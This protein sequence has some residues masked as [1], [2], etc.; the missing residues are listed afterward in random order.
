MKDQLGE[1]ADGLEFAKF[2]AKLRKNR[3]DLMARHSCKGVRFV[4][5]EKGGKAAI[6]ATAIR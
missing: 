4:A 3:A 1:P 2:S 6:K 5:Y